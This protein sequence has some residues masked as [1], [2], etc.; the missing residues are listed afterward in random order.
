MGCAAKLQQILQA[1]ALGAISS[2]AGQAELRQFQFVRAG[3]I[4]VH[5]PFPHYSC[6]SWQGQGSLLTDPQPAGCTQQESS[7]GQLQTREV[8][9]GV[10]GH[11]QPTAQG[12][13]PRGHSG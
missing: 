4:P 9:Q 6:V 3:C 11:S 7:P 13:L 10:Q 1:L 8:T 5:P 12:P 2:W